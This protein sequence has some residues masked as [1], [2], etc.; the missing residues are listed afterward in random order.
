MLFLLLACNPVTID[1]PPDDTQATTDDTQDTTDDTGDSQDTQDT[2]EGYPPLPYPTMSYDCADLP[3][4]YTVTPID[5]ARGYHGVAFD[6]DGKQ[7]G[8]DAA[9]AITKS[10]YGQAAIPWLPGM[11]WVEQMVEHPSGDLFVLTDRDLLRI[12]P[13][14]GYERVRGNFY[15]PYGLSFGPD[16]ML[17]VADGGLYRVDPETGESTTLIRVPSGPNANKLIRD[18]TFSLDSTTMYIVRTD[19]VQLKWALDENMEPVGDYEEWVTVPGYWKDGVEIDACG[20]FWIPEYDKRA[21]YRVTP[22]GEVQEILKGPERGYAHGLAWGEGDG[23]WREDSIYMPLP[24]NNAKIQEVHLGVPDG[25]LVR[26]W[27]GTK[28]SF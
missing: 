27:N 19:P 1:L 18:V 20:N 17:Y 15:Y 5:G 8:W 2:A 13:D 23:G 10:E 22:E 21:L 6:A 28:S 16:G 14:G 3:T 26:T 7:M 4:D 25:R 24:Y 12:S 11:S 9:N